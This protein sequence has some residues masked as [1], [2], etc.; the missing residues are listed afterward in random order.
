MMN[1]IHVLILPFDTILTP[2]T[3]LRYP[4]LFEFDWR[5]FAKA[6]SPKRS[7]TNDRNWPKAEISAAN[8][9]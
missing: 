8:A 1:M 9:V 3:K 4:H 5:S 2:R 6:L 7:M